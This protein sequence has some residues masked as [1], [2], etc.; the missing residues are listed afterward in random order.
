MIESIQQI[1]QKIEF[2]INRTSRNDPLRDELI[3]ANMECKKLLTNVNIENK[4]FNK[5]HPEL[6]I[7][8]MWLTNESN[9]I[10]Y[11]YIRYKTKRKGTLAFTKDGEIIKNRYPIFIEKQ[12]FIR[13]QNEYKHYR[14]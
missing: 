12:E 4:M 2:V 14:F 9:D 1:Q 13:V 5:N 6:K 10:N 11:N 7:G 3:M 8:E